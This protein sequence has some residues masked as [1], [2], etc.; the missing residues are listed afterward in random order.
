MPAERPLAVVTG[1]STGIGYELARC[2]AQDGCD[3]VVTADEAAIETVA[4]RLRDTGASVEPVRADL[5]TAEGVDLLW[6]AMRDRPVD[7]LMAN[8]GRGLGHAFLEQ[9]WDRIEEVIRLNVSGTTDLLHRA[10]QA[11]RR[12]GEGRILI[13][14][15]LAGEIPGSYQAVYNATK[16]YL[17]TL[18]WGV[19]NELG[20]SDVTVTCLMPGPTDTEFFHRADMEDTNVGQSDSK[21]DPGMVARKGY[22]AML[23][24]ASGVAPAT[25]TKL[26]SALSGIVPDS[27]LARMHRQMAQPQEND[28]G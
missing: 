20:D 14:G 12:R 16:A 25:M 17:D 18:S 4:S 27:V 26:Q 11:M 24:G 15:S 21:S 2:A 9:D 5:S 6:S 23:K 3:L 13:T 19:R 28:N 8:A 22:A 1:A 10:L 7:Y